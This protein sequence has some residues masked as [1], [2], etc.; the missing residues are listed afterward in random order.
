MS[1]ERK[2][3]KS[4]N[5]SLNR[6][7]YTIYRKHEM[8]PN[9]ERKTSPLASTSLGTACCWFLFF[10]FS[11]RVSE[12]RSS[13]FQ[14]M[15]QELISQSKSIILFTQ[16]AKETGKYSKSQNAQFNPILVDSSQKGVS[17]LGFS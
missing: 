14:E 12:L 10:C 1:S 17:Q 13:N 8:Q 16:R 7:I 5:L 15:S 11:I 9:L 2:T 4:E 6:T 3:K